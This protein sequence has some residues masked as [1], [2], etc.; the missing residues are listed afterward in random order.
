[1]LL[2]VLSALA[3]RNVDPWQEAAKLA[4]LPEESATKRLSSLITPLPGGPLAHGNPTT[5]AA[6]LITLLPRRANADVAPAKPL[7]GQ[8]A[9]PNLRAVISMIVINAIFMALLIG[10]QSIMAS[11]RP[12]SQADKD[13]A[14]ASGTVSPLIKPPSSN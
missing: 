7:H 12:P 2:S 8:G 4:L 1:M 13:H 9:A 6:R 10:T 5:I 11:H 3:R 14:L